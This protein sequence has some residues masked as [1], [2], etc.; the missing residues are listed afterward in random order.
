MSL[1]ATS[2]DLMALVRKTWIGSMNVANVPL[3][4][5]L[6]KDLDYARKLLEWSCEPSSRSNNGHGCR[7]GHRLETGGRM[8]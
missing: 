2:V 8:V 1:E 5:L 6:R 7:T 3:G 4:T